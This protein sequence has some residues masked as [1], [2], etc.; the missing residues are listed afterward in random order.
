[1]K[2]IT[3]EYKNT[4]SFGVVEKGVVINLPQAYAAFLEGGG[5]IDQASPSFPS[6]ME[7]LVQLGDDGIDVAKKVVEWALSSDAD[8]VEKPSIETVVLKAPLSNVTKVIGIGLNYADHCREQNIPLPESVLLF[9]KFPSSIIGPEETITWDPQMSKEVDYEAELAVIIGRTTSKISPEDVWEVVAGYSIVN[10]VSARDVQSAD[11]QW[12]RGKSFDTF[13][14]IGPYLVTRDEISDTDN[15]TIQ[16]R[17]NGQLVQDSNTKEM[18]FKIPDII[19]FISK[20]IT[21]VPGDIICTGTPDGVGYFRDPKVLL[22]SGDVV[23]IEIEGL[24]ILRNPV[25]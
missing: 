11:R 14:P 13:C 20:S 12:V 16:T 17:L 21:L 25:V 1:M 18:V 9:A 15:L 4:I 23:E 2:L 6:D 8:H 22:K 10:D 24:G 19:S 5:K 3:Y 7:S